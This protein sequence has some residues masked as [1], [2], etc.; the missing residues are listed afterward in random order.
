MREELVGMDGATIIDFDGRI[1][2]TGAILKIDAGSNEG[3]R[4]AAATN[5]ARYG[6]SIKISQDGQMQGFCPEKRSSSNIKLLFTV[7]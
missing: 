6:V 4:L 3:G 7:N 1:I 2:A 5:L